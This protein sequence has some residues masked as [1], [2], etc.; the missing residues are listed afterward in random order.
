VIAHA[1]A[2]PPKNSGCTDGISMRKVLCV[3]GPSAATIVAVHG[4]ADLIAVP[5]LASSGNVTGRVLEYELV[6]WAVPDD[7]RSPADGGSA[8]LVGISRSHKMPTAPAVFQMI[9]ATKFKRLRR[10][11]ANELAR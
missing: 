7:E 1:K 3:N 2:R 5:E 4:H 10:L 8:Y 11:K 6:Q 9:A